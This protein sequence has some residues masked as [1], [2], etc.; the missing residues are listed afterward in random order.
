MNA[1]LSRQEDDGRGN[2]MRDQGGRTGGVRKK[3]TVCKFWV[4]GRCLKGDK[5]EYLHEYIEDKVPI[6]SEFLH[7]GVCKKANCKFRHKLPPPCDWYQRGFCKH[8]K[9]KCSGTHTP[10]KACMAYLLGFCPNGP[11]CPDAQFATHHL[12]LFSTRCFHSSLPSP[13]FFFLKQSQV[14]GAADAP[15]SRT[16]AATTARHWFHT[17]IPCALRQV[18]CAAAHAVQHRS[19]SCARDAPSPW[20]CRCTAVLNLFTRISGPC[21]RKHSVTWHPFLV[22]FSVLSTSLVSFVFLHLSLFFSLPCE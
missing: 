9:H 2:G 10:R 13:S 15:C 3:D 18:G 17:P 4:Q 5:C 21:T 14:A 11:E 12:I 8:G 16:A 6:C 1:P 22:S 20:C 19:P 7:H